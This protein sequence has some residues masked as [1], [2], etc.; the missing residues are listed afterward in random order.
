MHRNPYTKF[1]FGYDIAADNS[2][3]INA[4]LSLNGFGSDISSNAF[5]WPLDELCI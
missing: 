4:I 1:F 2:L 3:T 5:F